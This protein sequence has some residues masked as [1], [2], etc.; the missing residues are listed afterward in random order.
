MNE[1]A[2]PGPA[3]FYGKY[4]GT[5][6][7]N[8]DVMQLGRVQVE[9]PAVLGQGRMSWAMPCTPYAGD[10]VGLFLVPPVGANVWV[11][12]EG[13]DPNSPILAGCFWGTGQVPASPAVADV[14]MLKT[15]AIS[16]ELSDLPG[17]GGVKVSVGS[18]AVS[19]T[20]TIEA[21]SS[22]FTVAMGSNKIAVSMSSVSINNGAL[23]V[24]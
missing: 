5:V 6:A 21:T 14:K 8:T 13:G 7:S 18:P 2:P 22:G 24:K 23:E 19:T 9:C 10:K 1:F 16:V 11:E 17:A 4:R 3:R 20:I 12:F 15:D